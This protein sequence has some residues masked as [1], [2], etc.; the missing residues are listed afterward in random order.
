MGQILLTDVRKKFLTK[1]YIC[2]VVENN[3][4]AANLSIYIQV[5][6]YL[7]LI[8]YGPNFTN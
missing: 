3:I 6:K 8:K 4:K 2:V 5:L 1:S 7:Y